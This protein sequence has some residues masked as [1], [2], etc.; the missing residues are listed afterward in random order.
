MQRSRSVV[1]ADAVSAITG[2][3][4]PEPSRRRSS[5]VAA[6]PSMTGIWQSMRTASNVARA[7]AASASSPFVAT[8]LS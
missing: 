5:R 3:R 7:S 8:S 2:V 1:I 4:R 6:Y